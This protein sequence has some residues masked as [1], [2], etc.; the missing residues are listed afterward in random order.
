MNQPDTVVEDD[1]T[2][3]ENAQKILTTSEIVSSQ[4]VARFEFSI[5]NSI[6]FRVMTERQKRAFS[7]DA[8][9]FTEYLIS[10]STNSLPSEKYSN[11][12]YLVSLV[13]EHH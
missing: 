4:Q 10:K 5:P 1:N 8:I 6:I 13:R 11:D 12:I 9:F 7:A 3:L 2:F